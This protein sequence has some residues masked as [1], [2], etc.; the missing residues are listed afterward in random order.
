MTAAPQGRMFL[1]EA[2]KR[3]VEASVTSTLRRAA[4]EVACAA[5]ELRAARPGTAGTTMIGSAAALMFEAFEI[6]QAIASQPLNGPWLA[7]ALSDGIVALSQQPA[8]LLQRWNPRVRALGLHE[9]GAAC[10][11]PRGRQEARPVRRRV[12][13]SAVVC[14][15][16]GSG[17]Q[18]PP[19]RRVIAALTYAGPG[20]LATSIDVC[21]SESD[22]R[23]V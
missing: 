18:L 1:L 21:L 15:P 5:H 4:S 3:D 17:S 20:R 19:R 23:V 13:L 22:Q 7:A 2:S 8:T 9:L 6:R 12:I 11:P 14:L 10:W 16:R